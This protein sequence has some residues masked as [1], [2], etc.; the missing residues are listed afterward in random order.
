MWTCHICGLPIPKTIATP[1]H[2]LYRTVDH[3][4]PKCKGGPDWRAN[5]KS[6]HLM[7]NRLKA[8]RDRLTLRQIDGLH[9]TARA[10]LVRL[11]VMV[12]N[13]QSAE[14]RQRLGLL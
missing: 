9:K 7:C 13:K 2:A 6:S 11:G 14:I 8:D 4:I 10:L 5:R 1:T 3:V 12:T